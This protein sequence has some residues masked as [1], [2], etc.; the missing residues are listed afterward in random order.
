ML[1]RSPIENGKFVRA[2]LK[3]SEL[4]GGMMI[5]PEGPFG[6]IGGLSSCAIT[7]SESFLKDWERRG[8]Q[9][10]EVWL[11]PNAQVS[12]LALARSE[13]MNEQ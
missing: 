1:N 3:L 4:P 5:G 9:Y 2:W 12:G 7:T 13:T 8:E 6:P 10:I 11:P